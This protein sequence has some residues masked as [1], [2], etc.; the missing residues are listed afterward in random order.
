MKA[1]HLYLLLHVFASVS[2]LVHTFE[3]VSITVALGVGAAA[4]GRT[5]YNY[6]HESCDAK[7]IGFNATGERVHL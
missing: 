5:I 4:L 3:P 6:L 7:W 2:L 1:A